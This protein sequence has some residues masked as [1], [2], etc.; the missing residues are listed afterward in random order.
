MVPELKTAAYLALLVAAGWLDLRTGRIPN[1]LTL[2]GLAV[3]LLLALPA[4]PAAVLLAC[5]G[6]GLALLVALPFFA[7]GALGGG[8]AKL[9]VAVGAFLG[10]ERLWSALLL[11]A[12]AGGLLALAESLRRRVLLVALLNAR[13]LI[14]HWSTLGRSGPRPALGEPGA[15]AIPYGVAIAVGSAL[16][17]FVAPFWWR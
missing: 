7:L 13:A 11:S 14:R 15:I 8:D 6:A 10:P 12:L 1:A 9:L 5:A 2:A 4:G 17:W 3:G 16:G